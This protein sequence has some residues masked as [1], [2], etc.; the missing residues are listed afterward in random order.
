MNNRLIRYALTYCVIGIFIAISSYP[1][2]AAISSDPGKIGIGA[3]ALGLG[4]AYTALSND[5]SAIFTNPAG[6]TL[7]DNVQFTSMYTNLFSEFDYKQLGCTFPLGSG[8][9]GAG[10]IGSSIDN[11]PIVPAASTENMRPQA[12]KKVSFHDDIFYFSYAENITRQ[13]SPFK[14]QGDVL[15][16]GSL[17]YFNKGSAELNGFSGFGI[18]ADLGLLYKWNPD[19]TFGCLYKNFLPHLGFIGSVKWD[20]TED[21]LPSLLRLGSSVKLNNYN[22]IFNID[23]DIDLSMQ[24]PLLFHLGSEWKPINAFAFRVG[25]DQLMNPIGN[26][27]YKDIGVYSNYTLGC[28]IE[29]A[30]IRFDYAYRAYY[31]EEPNHFFSFAY[32]GFPSDFTWINKPSRVANQSFGEA[33]F[34]PADITIVSPDRNIITSKS[35]IT[36]IGVATERVT[37]NIN[38]KNYIVSGSH[39]SPTF[40]CKIPIPNLGRNTIAIS[41]KQNDSDYP[42]YNKKVI[43]LPETG[44][45]RTSDISKLIIESET[46]FGHNDTIPRNEFIKNIFALAN[47]GPDKNNL[48]KNEFKPYVDIAV[49]NN[50]IAL[51][52][53]QLLFLN[54]DITWGEAL[55]FIEKLEGYPVKPSQDKYAHWAATYIKAA[56]DRQLI[57]F[58]WNNSPD[59]PITGRDLSDLLNRTL[60][61]KSKV[62]ETLDWL[63]GDEDITF[64]TGRKTVKLNKN[65]VLENTIRP[66]AM[67]NLRNDGSRLSK[68]FQDRNSTPG[69]IPFRRPERPADTAPPP[70]P[71]TAINNKLSFPALQPNSPA[72]NAEKN[73]STPQ[74]FSVPAQVIRPME[75]DSKYSNP[76]APAANTRFSRERENSAQGTT[77]TFPGNNNIAPLAPNIT[78]SVANNR[79]SQDIIKTANPER[80]PIPTVKPEVKAATNV[81]NLN[82]S[83]NKEIQRQQPEAKPEERTLRNIADLKELPEQPTYETSQDKNQP[84]NPEAQDTLGKYLVPHFPADNTIIVEINIDPKQIM[85][86]AAL[87]EAAKLSPRIYAAEMNEVTVYELFLPEIADTEVQRSIIKQ[88]RKLGYAAYQ[89]NTYK[90]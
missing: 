13:V 11:I 57:P 54:K 8:M 7:I 34:I 58:D 1:L 26:G 75:T 25:V 55:S 35:E 67:N 22:A 15:L 49:K 36:I 48:G 74:S 64:D 56:K 16:G 69:V 66:L 33:N 2:F 76:E 68:L 59:S 5:A 79:F 72:T 40:S 65:Q 18:N 60:I 71:A 50:L 24:K 38:D 84:F 88:L 51:P 28:G 52:N 78:E 77:Q 46:S 81:A 30:G 47:I 3:R 32:L 29:I 19:I 41:I 62:K 70:N 20:K 37:I 9:G 89:N 43:R 44:I 90:N 45:I 39:D 82:N 6:L 31:D 87:L 80:P 85:K 4:N 23:S 42:I 63:S 10:M 21:T 27:V 73:I 12:T 14:L 83:E 17:K 61:G 53:N 86:I